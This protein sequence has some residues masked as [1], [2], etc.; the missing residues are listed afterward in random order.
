MAQCTAL[1]S[2]YDVPEPVKPATRSAGA[3]WSRSSCLYASVADGGTRSLCTLGGAA[4]ALGA[5][6]VSTLNPVA[7]AK[8][9]SWPG[10]VTGM[11]QGEWLKSS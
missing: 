9:P 1:G 2:T 7:P 4:S 8:E 11:C 5:Q 6:T 10:R 3:M